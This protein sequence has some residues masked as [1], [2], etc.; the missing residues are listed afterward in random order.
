SADQDFTPL[1][2][3]GQLVLDAHA[4][5]YAD[6]SL[7]LEHLDIDNPAGGTRV[8]QLRGS[9]DHELLA[10]KDRRLA[11]RR[12]LSLKG[13][14]RQQLDRL[15]GKAAGVEAAGTLE[16][17]LDAESGDLALFRTEATV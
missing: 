17:A 15:R 16:V 2:A 14:V 1:Y 7:R 5:R 13:T 11:G 12:S 8:E 4:Y 9:I 6:G 3:I 10:H